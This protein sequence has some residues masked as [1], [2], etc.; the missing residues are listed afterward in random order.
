MHAL[1]DIDVLQCCSVAT[2]ISLLQQESDT[3]VLV[4]SA[5]LCCSICAQ[6]HSCLPDLNKV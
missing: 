4:N 6:A 3:E 1:R 5:I 2:M